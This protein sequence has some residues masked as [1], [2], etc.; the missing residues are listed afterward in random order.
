MA[1][2]APS[3]ARAAIEDAVEAQRRLLEPECVAE[4][5]GAAG[6]VSAALAAGGKLLLFG[7]GGSA[8]DASHIA[9]EFVARF[10]RERQALPAVSLSADQSALTA[11]ANDFGYER[12]FARQLEA[13]G[14]PSDVAMAISTS[15]RSLNVLEGARV[16][17]S[18]GL[19]TIGLTGADGGEL[20]GLV[21]VCLRA[22]ADVTARIQESHIVIAHIL[23]ELVERDIT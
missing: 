11:I 23:C 21:D 6:M 2:D 5:V 19:T 9:T 7:N 4:I 12:V 3:V 13:L 20:T 22:R 18:L 1:T 15:G 8:S 10:M 14:R 17:R 16:A